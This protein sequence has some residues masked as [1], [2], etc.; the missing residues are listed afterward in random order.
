MGHEINLEIFN[1]L[2]ILPNMYIN[3]DSYPPRVKVTGL[4]TPSKKLCH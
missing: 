1:K 4:T 3:L 2:A